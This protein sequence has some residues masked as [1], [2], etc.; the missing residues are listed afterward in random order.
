MASLR[1]APILLLR[2]EPMLH[3]LRGEAGFQL[4][5]RRVG[6]DDAVARARA[7]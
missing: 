2:T 4:L 3:P 5:L 7:S 1:L 6:L